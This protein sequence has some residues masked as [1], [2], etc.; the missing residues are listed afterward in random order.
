MNQWYKQLKTSP[1]GIHLIMYLV[2]CGL[3]YYFLYVLFS[4]VNGIYG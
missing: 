1:T 2:L 4:F 3:F